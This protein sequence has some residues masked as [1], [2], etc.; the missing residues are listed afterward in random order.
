MPYESSK[1]LLSGP[2]SFN[3][4]FFT[5]IL[6]ARSNAET[7]LKTSSN[8]RECLHPSPSMPS[9]ASPAHGKSPA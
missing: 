1:H 2:V 3:Q 7:P 5:T 8:A 4:S 9:S 6:T